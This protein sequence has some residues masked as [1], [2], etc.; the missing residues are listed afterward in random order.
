MVPV[1]KAQP[2]YLYNIIEILW[3]QQDNR[4][5]WVSYES[6]GENIHICRLSGEVLT[7]KIGKGKW[8]KVC[9][10]DRKQKESAVRKHRYHSRATC[11]PSWDTLMWSAE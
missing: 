11:G 5:M 4:P 8:R 7:T 3:T 9:E 2:S 10:V 6:G 1:P